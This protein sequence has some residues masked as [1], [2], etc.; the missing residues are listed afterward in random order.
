MLVFN[1]LYSVGLPEA[2]AKTANSITVGTVNTGKLTIPVKSSYKLEAKA[3]T[4]KLTYKSSKKKVA[5]VTSKG[6]VKAGKAGKAT[7]TIKGKGVTKKITVTVVKKKKYKKVKRIKVKSAPHKMYASDSKKLTIVFTPTNSSNKNLKF[8][9]SNTSIA[10]ISVNGVIK[11]KMRGSAKITVTSC[12]NK[13]AKKAFTLKV[14]KDT[15]LKVTFD[16]L[17]G[18]AVAMQKVEKGK[19]AKKPAIPTLSGATFGGWYI[20]GENKNFDFSTKITK[21]ITLYAKWN[22]NVKE[23][24]KD[25]EVTP[26]DLAL[27][28]AAGKT[29]VL[30]ETDNAAPRAI[31]G[32]I[33]N[34]KVTNT[35]NAADVL[36]SL[37]KNFN[38]VVDDDGALEETDFDVEAGEI[39]KSSVDT[40]A[41]EDGK[42]V[43]KEVFYKYTPTTKE[44]YKVE[45]ADMILCTD[46]DGKVTAV[47]STYDAAFRTVEFESNPNVTEDIAKRTACAHVRRL[48]DDD[49]N[50]ILPVAHEVPLNCDKCEIVMY[51]AVNENDIE[52]DDQGNTYASKPFYAYKVRVYPETSSDTSTSDDE[53]KGDPDNDST[54]ELPS[55]ENT[56]SSYCWDVYVDVKTGEVRR[57]IQNT[58]Y[59]DWTDT[60]YSGPWYKS[61][62]VKINLSTKTGSNN[63]RL[64]KYYDS[65]HDVSI[66]QVRTYQGVDSNGNDLYGTA[67]QF[68]DAT[69]TNYPDGFWQSNTLMYHAGKVIDFYKNKLGR[70][71]YDDKGSTIHI[72]YYANYLNNSTSANAYWSGQ[73]K[74][75]YFTIPDSKHNYARCL[76][77]LGHEFTHAVVG[78]TVSNGEGLEHD[79]ESGAIN[80]AYA[81]IFGEFIQGKIERGKDDTWTHSEDKARNGSFDPG[82]SLA[83]PSKYGNGSYRANYSDRYTGTQDSGGRHWNSTILSHAFYLMINDSNTSSISFDKWAKLYYRALSRLSHTAQFIDARYAIMAEAKS[84]LFTAKQQLA[85]ADAFDEVGIYDSE[86]IIITLKWGSQVKDLDLH[87]VGPRSTGYY[88]VDWKNRLVYNTSILLKRTLVATLDK[89]DRNSNGTEVIKVHKRYDGPYYAYITITNEY[90]NPNSTTFRKGVASVTV[91]L[92]KYKPYTFNIDSDAKGNVWVPFILTIKDGER[93]IL[94]YWSN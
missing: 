62:T 79:G 18:S 32:T 42:K 93:P 43:G 91:Q 2:K 54:G 73:N 5:K 39:K 76:D 36:K 44:G 7:I 81:D 21:N 72:G 75:I 74:R 3:K 86:S 6:V 68:R 40:P 94:L 9:S 29:E 45:G 28:Q 59:D 82:R 25:G 92:G 4:G 10:T 50:P 13:K 88:E 57:A 78:T 56:Y 30:G 90:N 47:H 22:V 20:N 80:E 64:Y 87:L 89:D 58:D 51:T 67:D 71:G 14:V 46:K 48:T 1:L 69:I 84:M 35:D 37:K 27:L 41:D 53:S 61:G 33:T 8:K 24:T 83:D 11:A 55:P 77:V 19:T 16:T 31:V 12:A 85:I 70:N 17:G 52:Y 66:S 65:K 23:L 63:Q 15:R 60:T 38:R 49:G 26:G 34:K